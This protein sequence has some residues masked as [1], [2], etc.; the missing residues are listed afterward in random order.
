MYYIYIELFFFYKLE[1]C[2]FDKFFVFL[3]SIIML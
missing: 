2:E 1:K 3:V